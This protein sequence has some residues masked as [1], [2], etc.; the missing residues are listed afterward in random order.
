MEFAPLYP[1]L[2]PILKRTFPNCIWSGSS[3]RSAIALTFDDGPHPQHTPQLLQVLD[4]YQIKASFFWLGACVNAAPTIA[5][6]VYERGH[7]IGLHGYR[8]ISFPSLKTDALKE[9]LEKTQTAIF[10]A[11][12]LEPKHIRDVRPPNGLFTPQTLKLLHQWQ[13][14]PI[15]WS[16]VP[17]D[18]VSPG[19]EVV[20]RR[21]IQQVRNGSLI[22]LHDGYYGGEDVAQTTARLIPLLLQQGYEFV[23]IEELPS[24]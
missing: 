14:R 13:Y 19:V 20:V 23:T 24:F 10:Q 21:V 18:W 1:I 17:E 3:E 15:M 11:C 22:V 7:W 5:R 9:S 12:Q 8:H 2:Y 16:V 4:R 6:E